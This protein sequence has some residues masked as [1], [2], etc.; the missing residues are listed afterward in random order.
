MVTTAQVLLTQGHIVCVDTG[1]VQV[2]RPPDGHVMLANMS[3]TDVEF[4][5]SSGV[6]R[7]G[8]E[9]GGLPAV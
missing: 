2:R 6:R 7:G 3:N 8:E 9:L 1:Q 4:V 5:C